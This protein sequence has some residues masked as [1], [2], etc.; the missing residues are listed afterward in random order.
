[1]NIFDRF[2]TVLSA[3]NQLPAPA[4]TP[5]V[6]PE[7]Q[8]PYSHRTKKYVTDEI[9]KRI[10]TA[11]RCANILSDDIAAMPFQ[12]FQRSGRNIQRV[13][14]DA[15]MRNTAYLLEVQ[16]N[17]W[18][19]PLI[20]KK[21]IIDWMIHWGNAYIWT[22][23]GPYREMFILAA[24]VTY[25]EFDPDGNLWYRTTFPSGKHE[26]IP[27][28]EIAHLMINPRNGLIGRSVL[29][30]ARDTIGRQLGA[31]ETQD[32]IN[33][34]G[35]KPAAIIWTK[36]EVKERAARQKI[37]EAYTESISGSENSGGVAL[38]DAKITKFEPVT[39]NPADAQ[40]LES[41][42]ATDAQIANFY[43][44]PLYKLNLGKQSYESN[45]QQNL[46]YLRTTLNP[47]LVQ[48]EQVGRVKWLR[49]EEQASRY[50]KFN[51]DSLLQTDAK[52]RAEYKKMMIESGQMTP[53]E[54]REIDDMSEYEGGD[55]HYFPA[56]M[57]KIQTD[58]SILGGTVQKTAV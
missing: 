16:P 54:G 43:G 9:S 28:V 42:E 10:S 18:M 2:R 32:R 27:S 31:L 13:M 12:M 58:G 1:M 56:N 7:I 15:V 35:L 37:K 14:P 23:S 24:D 47:Y 40:F 5:V 4:E 30:Y 53:N 21:T 6:Y 29:N 11:Y 34:D 3:K 49:L 8:W 57:G 38:F 20:F 17:R 44:M 39:M 22:P 45:E 50:L 41:I 33:G 52:S 48:W 55:A 25:P 26:R 19:V 36:D 46:D 51:R